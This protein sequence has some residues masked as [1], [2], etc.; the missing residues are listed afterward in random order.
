M[1]ADPVLFWTIVAAVGQV[2]GALAT[3]AAVITSL[4]VVLS[5]RRPKLR[6]TAGLRLIIPGDGAPASDAIGVTVAN[7][8]MRRVRCACVG[9]R[10][11]RLRWGP[12][13]L[14]RQH[15]L[16]NADYL[17]GSATLPFD[18]DLGDEKTL[19]LAVESYRDAVDAAK[20]A[21]FFLRTPP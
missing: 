18:L 17:P 4:W 7:V 8:G 21:A 11:S 12:R 10:T 9:W 6:V 5:E 1:R 3:A 13:W 19:I 15:A 20:R 2:A 14:R 16:Q